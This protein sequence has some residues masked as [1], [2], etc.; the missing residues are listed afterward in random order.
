MMACSTP[1]QPQCVGRRTGGPAGGQAGGQAGAPLPSGKSSLP[2]ALSATQAPFP[3]ATF[4]HPPTASICTASRLVPVWA[5]VVWGSG[6]SSNGTCQS[7][8][9]SPQLAGVAGLAQPWR[10]HCLSQALARR[11]FAE[12]STLCCIAPLAPCPPPSFAPTP[13]PAPSSSAEPLRTAPCPS[14]CPRDWSRPAS[15][16]S[17]SPR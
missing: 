11:A 13:C 3:T 8:P 14:P 10:L 1:A 2:Q 17:C 5:Y 12:A 6:H 9:V 15:H 4:C 16:T 7:E